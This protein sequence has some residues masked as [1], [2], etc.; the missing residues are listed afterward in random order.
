MFVNVPE[1]VTETCSEGNEPN[2]I[3]IPGSVWL[4]ETVQDVIIPGVGCNGSGSSRVGG[5]VSTSSS[6][7]RTS[8]N[9]TPS[10]TDDKEDGVLFIDI[11][12]LD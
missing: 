11:F 7:N 3:E 1:I 5:T 2:V 6:I 12:A 8:V 10:F 9:G 4:D